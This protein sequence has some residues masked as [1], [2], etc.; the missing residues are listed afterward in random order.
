MPSSLAGLAK[1]NALQKCLPL[2]NASGHLPKPIR[3]KEK[4]TPF[5]FAMK[6]AGCT[7]RA[8]AGAMRKRPLST[9]AGSDDG[10]SRW[11]GDVSGP[12]PPPI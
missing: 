8:A 3:P 7:R 2:N 11:L 6:L 5:L 9:G 12:A 10:A 4:A 1:E